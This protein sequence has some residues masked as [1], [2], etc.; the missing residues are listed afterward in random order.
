MVNNKNLY[1][2]SKMNINDH[3]TSRED[4]S[5]YMT[6]D[7]DRQLFE[8][9]KIQRDADRPFEKTLRGDQHVNCHRNVCPTYPHHK[10]R[11]IFYNNKIVPAL[12]TVNVYPNPLNF[13]ENQVFEMRHIN[14]V[15]DLNCQSIG[16]FLQHQL[17]KELIIQDCT[18]TDLQLSYILSGVIIETNVFSL[19]KV[20]IGGQNCEI[21]PLSIKVL[22]DLLIAKGRWANLTPLRKADILALHSSS[23][24]ALTYEKLRSLT[25][26]SPNINI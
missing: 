9:V 22:K 10:Q 21:G 24:S 12:R 2:L 5:T 23:R 19:W 4:V 14:D 11:A 6:K 20:H 1:A 7:Y 18:L 3:H 8:Y 26:S 25:I 15:Q 16:A 17:L 13:L